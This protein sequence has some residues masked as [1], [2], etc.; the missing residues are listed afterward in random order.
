MLSPQASIAAPTLTIMQG[1]EAKKRLLLV[2]NPTHPFTPYCSISRNHSP[3][4][5]RTQVRWLKSE[6]VNHYTVLLATMHWQNVVF[7]PNVWEKGNRESRLNEAR[8][9]TCAWVASIHHMRRPLEKYHDRL[10]G[11]NITWNLMNFMNVFPSSIPHLVG[12][13]YTRTQLTLCR[14]AQSDSIIALVFNS[15]NN[16]FRRVS[17]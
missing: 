13:K 12:T 16:V 10:F 5:N 17:S 4:A 7:K 8:C 6:H 9:V 11:C 15:F 2:Y 14:F 3:S 1:F